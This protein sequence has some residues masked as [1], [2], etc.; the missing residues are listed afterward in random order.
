LRWGYAVYGGLG[1]I[2][3]LLQNNLKQKKL[4]RFFPIGKPLRKNLLNRAL[5]QSIVFKPIGTRI[6]GLFYFE[7]SLRIGSIFAG[8]SEPLI[9]PFT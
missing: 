6:A 4:S 2:R 1:G 7:T 8:Q 3:A 9:R 5:R